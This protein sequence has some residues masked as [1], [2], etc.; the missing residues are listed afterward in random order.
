[1][2]KLKVIHVYKSFNVYNGLIEILTI[3]AQN[4]NH[5]LY[6]L[7]V[8]VYEYD[9]NEFGKKFQQ[10]GGKIYNLNISP[11]LATKHQEFTALY[12]F[13]KQHK[14]DIVQTH[15]LKANIYGTMAAK[16]AKVPVIIA[17]EM[18]LKD[19]ASTRLKRFRDRLLH[20]IVSLIISK[21]DRFMVTSE[22]IKNEW[23]DSRSK[24]RFEVIYPPFNLEKYDIANS[25]PLVTSDSFGKRIGFVGRLSE[26]KSVKTLINAIAIVVKSYPGVTLS[27]VGTGP[28]ELE[29]KSLCN[30]LNLN[31]NITFEGHKANSFESLKNMDVFVL[32]S[33]TEGCPIVILEAMAMGLPVIA[34]NVGGNPELV[35]DGR[36]G[37]LVPVDSSECMAASI[38]KL[39]S[40]R[41][42]SRE[43]GQNGKNRAF[44][45]F[46]P[47]SFTN[48]LQMLYSHLAG[49]N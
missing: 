29:L 6:E 25:K 13:F 31:S 8:C 27:I 12:K 36:T 17:T 38:E 40:N 32:P 30:E 44:T 3:L 5:D 23:V 24:D 4:M 34:T 26:E 2:S 15:V 39:I 28:K 19:I 14:P 43:L 33:R 47:Y 48:K 9:N 49:N 41:R 1:M 42:L 20:P 37:Y 45:D 35:I 21:C 22:F 18:T 7:G 10:L 11:K 16:M 46:H